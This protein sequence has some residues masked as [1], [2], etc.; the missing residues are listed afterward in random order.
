MVNKELYKAK[1]VSQVFLDLGIKMEQTIANDH[2]T[3]CALCKQLYPP[4]L[5]VLDLAC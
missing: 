5:A 2:T 3:A 4:W 1:I